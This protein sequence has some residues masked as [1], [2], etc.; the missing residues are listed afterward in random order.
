MKFNI[1]V[2]LVESYTKSEYE[3]R[4]K[5]AKAGFRSNSVETI[6]GTDGEVYIQLTGM[7]DIVDIN[8]KM[9][10]LLKTDEQFANIT[11]FVVDNEHIGARVRLARKKNEISN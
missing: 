1:C 11:F 5:L 4:M 9:I 2:D 6:T 8:A 3:I 10:T 7:F